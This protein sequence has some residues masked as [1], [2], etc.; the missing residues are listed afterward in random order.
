MDASTQQDNARDRSSAAAKPVEPIPFDSN[1][2]SALDMEM[3]I[4]LDNSNDADGFSMMPE[5]T[6]SP[7]SF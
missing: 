3:L 6:L 5:G 4:S 7:R 2:A 1:M